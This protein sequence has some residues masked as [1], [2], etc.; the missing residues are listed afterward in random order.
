PAKRPTKF[1]MRGQDPGD[2]FEDTQVRAREGKGTLERRAPG[3]FGVPGPEHALRADFPR[4]DRIG[5]RCLEW[6][7]A[8]ERHIIHVQLMDRPPLWLAVWL[9]RNDHEP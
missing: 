2:A 5:Q 4:G 8:I 6:H 1:S 7:G 9:R 3:L